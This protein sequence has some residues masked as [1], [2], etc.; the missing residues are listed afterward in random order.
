MK[1]EPKITQTK[2]GPKV[3][4]LTSDR[5]SWMVEQISIVPFG[6]CYRFSGAGTEYLGDRVYA[7]DLKEAV[8][9]FRVFLAGRENDRI[10]FHYPGL[11]KAYEDAHVNSD[12]DG[13]GDEGAG[14]DTH[15][16][17]AEFMESPAMQ[18]YL[19]EYLEANRD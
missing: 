8:K 16:A 14:Y 7:R 3:W 9:T 18:S 19:K 10:E 2:I 6:R 1:Q 15:K 4:N 12:I 11:V 5:W 17:L 13:Y